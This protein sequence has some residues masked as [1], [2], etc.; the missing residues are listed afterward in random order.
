MPPGRLTKQQCKWPPYTEIAVY[1]DNLKRLNSEI[2]SYGNQL[3]VSFRHTLNIWWHRGTVMNYGKYD[4]VSLIRNVIF[5]NLVP[6]SKFE[7]RN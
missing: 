1:V 5:T 6:L 2:A 4:S 7:E 3:I